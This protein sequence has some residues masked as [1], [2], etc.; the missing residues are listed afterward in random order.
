MKKL[1]ALY[2]DD[3]IQWKGG[4]KKQAE[5]AI[6]AAKWAFG[7]S[8]GKPCYERKLAAAAALFYEIIMLHPLADGNKRLAV[9][10]LGSFQSRAC[11]PPQAQAQCIRQHSE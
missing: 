1:K 6:A 5:Q 8:K 7:F 9:V 10:M 11:F 4:G 3:Y 2:P